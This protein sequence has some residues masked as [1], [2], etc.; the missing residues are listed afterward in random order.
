MAFSQAPR[1]IGPSFKSSWY[2]PGKKILFTFGL[3]LQKDVCVQLYTKTSSSAC[4]RSTGIEI[5]FQDLMN[6]RCAPMHALIHFGLTPPQRA[7]GTRRQTSSNS[8]K[9]SLSWV[10]SSLTGPLASMGWWS[11]S[12]AKRF[13]RPKA[14]MHVMIRCT[15]HVGWVERM[16]NIGELRTILWKMSGCSS[17]SVQ[18]TRQPMLWATTSSS[19]LGSSCRSLSVTALRS[20]TYCEKLSMTE[21]CRCAQGYRELR[22]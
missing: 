17:S 18:A 14:E 10:S 7:K 21:H 4:S 8:L 15:S 19:P 12:G 13:P 1:T 22:P 11:G 6:R 2:A 16:A 5:R 3:A 9:R 20:S